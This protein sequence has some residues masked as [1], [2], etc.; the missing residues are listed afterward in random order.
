[1]LVH[2]ACD[3]LFAGAVL[4]RDQHAAGARRGLADLVED[5]LHGGA[6]ADH[7]EVGGSAAAQPRVLAAQLRERQRVL[8]RDQ[9]FVAA[10][11]LFDEVVRAG[12]GRVDGGLD[13]GVTGHHHDNDVVLRR[14]DLGQY[15]EAGLARHHHV[16]EHQIDVM[17]G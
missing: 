6:L 14:P 15:F 16:E 2:R 13:R 9:Q 7:R 10:Q 3:E 8:D 5:R 17:L 4:A 12:L 11:W 1:M